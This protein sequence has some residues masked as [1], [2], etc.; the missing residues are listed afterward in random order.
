MCEEYANAILTL[1]F[2]GTWEQYAY[3]CNDS[4]VFTVAGQ[5]VYYCFECG[6]FNDKVNDA[7]YRIYD[8]QHEAIREMASDYL[9][10]D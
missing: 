6:R 1:L 3:L 2:N 10:L 8:I 5:E 7:N 4:L 9:E